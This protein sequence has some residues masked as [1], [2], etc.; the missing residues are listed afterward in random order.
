MLASVVYPFEADISGTAE[1]GP[2]KAQVLI[3]QS[4]LLTKIREMLG[5]VRR[6]V[7]R[8]RQPVSSSR[9]GSRT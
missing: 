3:I 2:D 7:N 6:R 5:L 8:R 1:L 4:A 9:T